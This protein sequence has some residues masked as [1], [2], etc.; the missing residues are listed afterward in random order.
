[1]D[2]ALEL[3]RETWAWLDDLPLR[4][5]SDS[6]LGLMR[7]KVVA[8]GGCEPYREPLIEVEKEN[9]SDD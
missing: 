2:A 6:P 7:S 3:L 9:R 1:M 5:C 4:P 8:I